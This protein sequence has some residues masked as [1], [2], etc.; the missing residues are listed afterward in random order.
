VRGLHL[1]VCLVAGI[2]LVDAEVPGLTAIIG[3]DA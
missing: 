2:V 3:G 1:A